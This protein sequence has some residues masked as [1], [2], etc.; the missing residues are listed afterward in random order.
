MVLAD[1]RP[2][3][4]DRHHTELVDL[5]QL[6]R[7]GLRGTGHAGELVVEAEVVLQGD[8]G[9][10]LVLGLDLHPLLG[11]DGLV[12]ALVVTPAQQHATGELVDDQH[13]AVADDVV[14]V[15]VEQ[16]LGLDGVVEVAHQ[17]RVGGLIQVVDAQLVLD[18]FHTQ[19]VH[20]DGALADVHFV[21]GVLVHQRHD[22]RELGVPVGGAVCRTRD[23]QRGA[24]FVDEDR[25][26]L[27]DDGE[28]VSAL[29]QLVE[30]VGHI[31][32]QVVE[33]ELVVGA[34]GDVGVVGLAAF[35]RRHL[36]QDHAHLQ[37]Q[38]AV[39]AAHPL[40]VTF[41]QVVVDG[42]DVRALTGQRVQVRGQHTGEGL[43]FTGLHLGDVSGVQR[44]TTH[45]L[46]IKVPL[47]QHAPGRLAR[48]RECLG[49]QVV[50]GL[51]LFQASLELA[52]LGL[53]FG[54]GELLDVVGQGVDV[55]GH[56]LETLDHATFTK[57]QQLRQHVN[58]PCTR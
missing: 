28:G 8:R 38:E 39:H 31:V 54:I 14:L 2:V 49:H 35:R 55:I 44:G 45:D 7:L 47:A 37:P 10:R 23:D 16:F 27:V 11:L 52:G 36:R 48:D 57:A 29:H 6:G 20:T 21:V 32:A 19:L 4:G 24:G 53:Q 3:R 22:P 5:V 15:P 25:V 43:A 13:L 42:H 40:R 41:G 34:V 18:E 50:E 51:A 9:Q 33:A 17:R 26:D 46:H 12:H 58:N 30:R 1:H 56:A